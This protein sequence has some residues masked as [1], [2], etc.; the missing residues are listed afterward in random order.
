MVGNVSEMG[1]IWWVNGHRAGQNASHFVPPSYQ[2][3]GTMNPVLSV[4]YVQFQDYFTWRHNI[5]SGGTAARTI[6][7]SFYM[8]E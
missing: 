1:L 2:F 3:H 6:A 7:G 4:S 8:A 5:G